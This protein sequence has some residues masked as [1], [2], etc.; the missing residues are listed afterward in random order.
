[1]SR[2]S[3]LAWWM[4][5]GLLVGG[6]L[7]R[8]AAKPPDL[9]AKCEVEC[10]PEETAASTSGEEGSVAIDV[11]CPCLW[12]SCRSLC[13]SL[14]RSLGWL[15]GTQPAARESAGSEAEEE[16]SS[17]A[18]PE[19]VP[20]PAPSQFT[21]P[22]LRE[23][24]AEENRKPAAPADLKGDIL[25]NLGKLKEARELYQ[26]A[27]DW[28]RQGRAEEAC[29]L[30]DQVQRLCPGS[31]YD[32]MAAHQ[33]Q[34]WHARSPFP[35]PEGAAEEQEA[36]PETFPGQEITEL[37]KDCRRAFREGQLAEAGELAELALEL[38]PDLV[39]ASPLV[40]K[41]HLLT[42]VQESQGFLPHLVQDLQ[43]LQKEFAWFWS[44]HSEAKAVDPG[45]G[46]DFERILTEEEEHPSTG[47]S[48]ETK[49]PG[50]SGW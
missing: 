23:K 7:S 6:G 31:R 12:E 2:Y 22:Y 21:C 47:P 14:G 33:L 24:E 16:P 36:L 3:L 25:E 26:M 17:S 34:Q 19:A 43:D 10:I 15:A 32:Q 41:M 4:T 9:P 29:L 18:L 50:R 39:A 28:Q 44:S 30:L 13:E 46:S 1:M 37:L 11:T 45:T 49:E 42:Q 40:Y 5:A 38:C 48:G 35:F 27:E 8:A 20:E